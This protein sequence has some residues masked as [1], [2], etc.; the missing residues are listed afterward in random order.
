MGFS[1]KSNVTTWSTWGTSSPRDVMSVHTSTKHERRRERVS[2]RALVALAA[3][4]PGDDVHRQAE[5]VGAA[6][7]DEDLLESGQRRG[8]G[9]GR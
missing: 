4:P 2:R 5:L 8:G 7:V 6:Y 9:P 3:L 1:G